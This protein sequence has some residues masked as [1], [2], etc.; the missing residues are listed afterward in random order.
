MN[1]LKYL[2]AALLG[3]LLFLSLSLFGLA[4]TLK[5]TVLN[6]DFITSQ[7]E[8][9]DI[10]A[11]TEEAEIQPAIEEFPE[12]AQYPELESYVKDAITEYEGEIKKR[13]SIAI[14]DIYDYLLG[15]SQSLDLAL[16]LGDSVL[17]PEL[18]ISILNDIDLSPLVEELFREQAPM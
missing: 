14:N 6:A 8:K 1:S 10:A 11:L 7:L 17:D 4:L 12:L 15:K 13:V 3:L 5:M 2:A 16:V 18:T 9:L